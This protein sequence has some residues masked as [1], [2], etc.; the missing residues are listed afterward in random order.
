[1]KKSGPNVNRF[2]AIL[3]LLLLILQGCHY[4]LRSSEG[5][6]ISAAQVQEI[7]LGKTTEMDLFRILGPPSKKER[8]A[9][10]SERLLYLHSEI[11]SPTLPGGY[12]I[13]GFLEKENEEAFE[14]IL[15][16]GVVQSF[17][18]LKP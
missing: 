18:F 12:V 4:A 7:M 16:E 6:K 13:Y 11:L 9:D 3:L 14:V 1:M 8:K 17:H 10:G 15:K 2:F 5:T